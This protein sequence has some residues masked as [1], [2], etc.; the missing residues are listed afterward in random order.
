MPQAINTIALTL[1][2][3]ADLALFMF[4]LLKR[5]APGIYDAR[6]IGI[7]PVRAT[8]PHRRHCA[9]IRPDA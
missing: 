4:H 8:G 5:L 3:T 1:S 9:D 6:A 7:S 2:H